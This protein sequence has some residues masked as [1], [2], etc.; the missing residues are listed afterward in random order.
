MAKTKNNTPKNTESLSDIISPIMNYLITIENIP[1]DE[2]NSHLIYT[3]GVPRN[4]IMETD[5]SYSETLKV[6]DDLKLIKLRPSEES[7][8][9]EF[10]QYIVTLINKN[11]LIDTKRL[12]LEEQ[13]LTLKSKFN[14]E[15]KELMDQL[16]NT[17]SDK[18]DENEGKN[19]E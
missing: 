15:Q 19:N 7:S 5:Y 16:Y 8:I 4:W 3:M 2:N 13:I 18:S 17:D 9:D 12:Q 6:T 1:L 11:L 14:E 10:F